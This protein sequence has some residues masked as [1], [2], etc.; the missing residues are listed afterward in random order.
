RSG[1]FMQQ[2]QAEEMFP[3]QR[4]ISINGLGFLIS[5]SGYYRLPDAIDECRSAGSCCQLPTMPPHPA[6]HRPWRQ[7]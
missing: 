1:V 3:T 6:R 5:F 2:Q 7:P 4:G